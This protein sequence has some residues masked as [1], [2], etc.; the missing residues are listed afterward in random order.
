MQYLL[1]TNICIFVIRQKPTI[2]LSRFQQ[3]QPG[4]LGISTI[5]LSELRFGADKSVD[6]SVN[7]ATLDQFVAPLEIAEYD[8][9]CA[10]WYGK[11]RS[12][13]E[14]RGCKI[15]ALDTLI[16]A[17]ALRLGVPI[18]SNNVGEFSRVTGLSVED[19]TQP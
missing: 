12:D 9:E 18:I 8:A 7:H 4:D 3:F 6:P 14:R 13:L 15:G 16:A 11:V 5:T 10:D 2:V 19:W 17:H 1:D